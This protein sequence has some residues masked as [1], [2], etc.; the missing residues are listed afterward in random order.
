MTQAHFAI[1]L[2]Y[3]ELVA[4]IKAIADKIN[5][6]ESALLC[7]RIHSRRKADLA[8]YG[9][10]VFDY[11][12]YFGRHHDSAENRIAGHNLGERRLFKHIVN[13]HNVLFKRSYVE[14]AV[15]RN[16]L[17]RNLLHTYNAVTELFVNVGKLFCNGILCVDNIITVENRKRLVA[18]KA[19][20]AIYSVRKALSLLLTFKI[21][22]G[23][24][25]ARKHAL[26]EVTLCRVALKVK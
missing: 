20:G 23:D 25:R 5:G 18:D 10:R 11:S 13:L 16:V 4:H 2:E 14:C 6:V 1:R 21:N 7:K 3:A 22:I 8:V 26:V 19:L 9:R 24:V 12:E 17:T 15:F